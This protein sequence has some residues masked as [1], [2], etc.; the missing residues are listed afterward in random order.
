MT[1]T[2]QLLAALIATVASVT[3]AQAQTIQEIDP[4]KLLRFEVASVK[5]GDPNAYTRGI[6]MLPGQLRYGSPFF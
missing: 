2:R 5:P 3:V 6:G 1:R 4:A